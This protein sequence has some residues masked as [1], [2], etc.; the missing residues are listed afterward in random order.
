MKDIEFKLAVAVEVAKNPK[1]WK[2]TYGNKSL[3]EV[4]SAEGMGC[5]DL[6]RMGVEPKEA[7]RLSVEKNGH[8]IKRTIFIV[9]KSA[10]D[11]KG[12]EVQK[13]KEMPKVCVLRKKSGEVRTYYRS[14]N[15]Y[16]RDLKGRYL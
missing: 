6:C 15:R 9:K 10:K 3:A 8:A 1:L 5:E 13:P 16:V 2:A 7:V 11:Y 14:G 4:M 12:A